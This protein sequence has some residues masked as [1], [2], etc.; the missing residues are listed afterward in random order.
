M[1]I[2]LEI[3]FY[4]QLGKLTA[5]YLQF[6]SITKIEYLR[7]FEQDTLF[8][9]IVLE[10][11][12]FDFDNI[13]RYYHRKNQQDNYDNHNK[14]I[15]EQNCLSS[16]GLRSIRSTLYHPY[17][18]KD[19]DVITA[20]K[21]ICNN[22]TFNQIMDKN[23]FHYYYLSD[24]IDIEFIKFINSSRYSIGYFIS[25]KSRK[26][27]YPLKPIL[28]YQMKNILYDK[29]HNFVSLDLFNFTRHLSLYYFKNIRLSS[30]SM[31]KVVIAKIPPEKLFLIFLGNLGFFGNISGIFQ[32]FGEFIRF[33]HH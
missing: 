11:N 12:N 27:M 29:E 32:I 4:S 13:I 24:G 7:K 26:D 3:L 1:K 2:Y 23:F 9:S 25:Q 6:N 21:F 5:E 31:A 15:A 28:T 22:I 16:Y 17:N 10:F 14:Y 18:D 30:S 8:I 20:I 33:Y 19:N